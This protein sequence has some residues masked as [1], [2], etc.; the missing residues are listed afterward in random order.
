MP[1][2]SLRLFR[3]LLEPRPQGPAH[4]LLVIAEESM[5]AVDALKMTLDDLQEVYAALQA[6][7][8]GNNA[9]PSSYEEN[10]S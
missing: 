4:S 3:A 7:V 6:L 5:I 1:L 2:D 8:D 9:Q 10:Q